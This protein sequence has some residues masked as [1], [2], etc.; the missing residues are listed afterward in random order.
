M[1][2]PSIL[3]FDIETSPM[4]VPVFRLGKQH[5]NHSQIMKREQV[6]CIS[7]A[8]NNQKVQHG[9]FDL[10][11]YDLRKKDDDADYELIK[12]FSEMAESADIVVG[13]NAKF[14]DVGKLKSRIVKHKL[15]PLT[16]FLVDDTYLQT[17]CIG[18]ASH[19]LDDLGDYL[20]YGKKLPHGD[21][22][23]WWVGV[24]T[25]D[26][27]YLEK[28][29]KYCDRDVV[30]LRQIYQHLAPYMQSNLNMAA[31]NESLCCTNP[32][33]GSYDLE[34]RGYRRTRVGKFQRYQCK[35]CGTWVSDGKNLLVKPSKLGR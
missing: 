33:C 23:E 19:K 26:Q 10:S 29:A 12:N 1:T 18:F 21:G 13:H 2:S 7:W 8:W 15:P 20:G 6:I 35:K 30:R 31:V 14:F 22:M 5:V 16:P 17:K 4:L 25:G 24:I 32:S 28:M 34:R 11:K 3:Y 9:I 27:K